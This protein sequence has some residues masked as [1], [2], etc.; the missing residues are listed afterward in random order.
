VHLRTSALVEQ[1]ASV[2]S[3]DMAVRGMHVV[4]MLHAESEDGSQ[5]PWTP[6][7]VLVAQMKEGLGHVIEDSGRES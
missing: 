1:N 2:H 4:G 3:V 7:R 6:R 5:Q